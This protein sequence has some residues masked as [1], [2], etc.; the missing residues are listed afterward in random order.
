MPKID[1][2]TDPSLSESA[3]KIQAGIY[4]KMSFTQKWEKAQQLRE[5]AWAM[6]IA[7]VKSQHPEWTDQKVQEEVRRI[8]LY[9]TT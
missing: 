9:A 4:S 2:K 5:I 6:K 1:L 7:G 8:F 3:E